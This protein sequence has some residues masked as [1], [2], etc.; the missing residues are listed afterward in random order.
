MSIKNLRLKL[1]RKLH[2]QY[3]GPF[4]VLKQVGPLAYKLDLSHSY[5][6]KI[7]HPVF[8]VSLLRDFEDNELR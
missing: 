8:H 6:L 1:P 2:D 5:A 3:V 7:I 4:E